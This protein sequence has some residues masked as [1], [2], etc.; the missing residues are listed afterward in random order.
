MNES[1]ELIDCTQDDDEDQSESLGYF[2]VSRRKN[3]K[4]RKLAFEAN[5]IVAEFENSTD[6]SFQIIV[7]GY[8]SQ[9]AYKKLTSF[10]FVID[11]S[12]SNT[13]FDCSGFKRAALLVSADYLT[14]MLVLRRGLEVIGL[15][16]N[17]EQKFFDDTTFNYWKHV[18]FIY[19]IES[20]QLDLPS[21]E[22]KGGRRI[23]I[24]LFF[25]SNLVFDCALDDQPFTNQNC[26][27][28]TVMNE[29]FNHPKV[30]LNANYSEPHLDVM[31]SVLEQVR[32]CHD[33]QESTVYLIQPEKL[34]PTLRNYQKKAVQWMLKREKQTSESDTKSDSKPHPLW[35]FNSTLNLQYNFYGGFFRSSRDEMILGPKA[36][37]GILADEM[38][39]GKTV[40]ILALLLTHLRPESEIEAP[41]IVPLSGKKHQARY[42][43]RCGVKTRTEYATPIS[44]LRCRSIQHKEC[45]KFNATKWKHL[46]YYC[47]NCWDDPNIS[48]L[49]SRATFIITPNSIHHQWKQ[50][51]RK[52]VDLR[53]LKVLEYKGVSANYI[54]PYELADQDI[55]L[56][57]YETLAN[58]LRFVDLPKEERLRRPKRFNQP[59]TPLTAINWWRVVL[60]E[61]QM[62]ESVSTNAAT[63]AGIL[64]TV[65]HWCVTGTPIQKSVNDIFGLIMFIG[66]KPYCSRL[67]WKLLI[68]DPYCKENSEP[69]TNLLKECFWRNTK[70]DVA[71]ELGLPERTEH[72]IKVDLALIEKHFYVRQKEKCLRMFAECCRM[73]YLD[74]LDVALKRMDN[75]SCQMLMNPLLK[76]R[77]A[78]CHPQIAGAQIMTMSKKTMTMEEV[79]ETMIKRTSYECEEH[80]R[81]LI[82][83]LNGQAGIQIIKKDYSK[84]IEIYR[85]V[86]TSIESFKEKF[87]TDKLQL[88]HT[89]YNL[90]DIIKTIKGKQK[91]SIT[92]CEDTVG[93]KSPTTV[94]MDQIGNTLRDENLSTET[95]SIRNEYLA[96]ADTA[97]Q[98][99]REQLK[100]IMENT[101]SQVSILSSDWWIEALG[102][103]IDKNEEAAFTSR[104]KEGLEER[105][106]RSLVK[107]GKVY[108]YL[109]GKHRQISGLELI[110]VMSLDEIKMIREKLIDSVVS[111]KSKPDDLEF[112]QAIECHL[113]PGKDEE[114]NIAPGPKCS[115]C[116]IHETFNDYE[117]KLY[118]LLEKQKIN[119]KR[120]FADEDEDEVDVNILEEQRKGNW[121]KSETEQV[122]KTISSFISKYDNSTES[123]REKAK[124][125][126]ELFE[127][128]KKEFRALRSV[129]ISIF[130]FVSRLDELNMAT[131][132]LRKIHRNE[133]KPDESINY[134]LEAHEI[135]PNLIQLQ[136]DEKI[137]KA[138]LQ[139]NLSHLN[140]LTNLKKSN[141]CKEGGSN[142][143]PCP[144]CMHLLGKTWSSLS[145]G[146]SYCLSCCNLMIDDSGAEMDKP[147]GQFRSI[148]CPIC[149]QFTKINDI[150]HVATNSVNSDEDKIQVKGSWS[151]KVEEIVRTLLQIRSK[152]PSDKC[153]L[154]SSWTSFLILIGRALS[155]NG[156]SHILAD[157]P[158]KFTIKID[159]F[160]TGDIS[161]LLMPIHLGSKG[162]NLI[163][164]NHALL[165]EPLLDP[166][167]EYQA[168]GRIHRIGQTKP[169]HVYRFIVNQTIEEKINEMFSLSFNYNAY[170][171]LIDNQGVCNTVKDIYDLLLADVSSKM[172]IEND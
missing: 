54:Y 139:K 41:D 166:S 77:Q 69:L 68:A 164:A 104:L 7:D 52:H 147:E 45:I 108:Q 162:L 66:E 143:E 123:Q 91:D 148:R 117:G 38:G 94:S 169:T 101:S 42:L 134:I 15:T 83:S 65:N 163:E 30:D 63:M 153:L 48:K 33:Q 105:A 112:N 171:N 21:N 120:R 90:T 47:P 51:I 13:N 113:R 76:L 124:K 96:T 75:K 116:L 61:A 28:L 135:E 23:K 9:F 168:I 106:L 19:S 159:E 46:P 137:S 82:A 40:E 129:W 111:M 78:C 86:L 8:N 29:I 80:H 55:V 31:S 99:A 4:R 5:P 121:S 160:K 93:D 157:K 130:D 43:C 32:K 26:N 132:R 87:R 50:E 58:E 79:L 97:I 34:R 10:H 89:L 85:S 151:S 39:L 18:N 128:L 56:A 131:I 167:H 118:F 110:I 64:S 109:T 126:L 119:R 100:S 67:W 142:P 71:R 156:I 138:D 114:G 161:V 44:C 35:T 165:V 152:A 17:L 6:Y 158:K 14:S 107:Q 2:R 73:A 122:L 95:D 146:H 20:D 155:E 27:V 3:Q 133:L 127:Q 36:L 144:V 102:M 81:K 49:K 154:F 74:D 1:I 136:A 115:Y 72:I 170:S 149:R 92:L 62:V 57:S 84:A 12:D 25:K 103:I 125:M 59:P 24:D 16:G 11:S 60:D 150:I 172:E 141:F 140:F 22:I 88:Y 70:D 53:S 145:C 37:G 98:E